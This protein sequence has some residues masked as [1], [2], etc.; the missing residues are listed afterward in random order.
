MDLILCGILI[1]AFLFAL[2]ELITDGFDTV[3]NVFKYGLKY[4]IIGILVV[5]GI[6]VMVGLTRLIWFY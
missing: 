4:T 5:T 1:S 6:M 2:A 3:K